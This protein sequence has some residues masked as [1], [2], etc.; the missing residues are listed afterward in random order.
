[1]L[2]LFPVVVMLMV[3][4]MCVVDIVVVVVPIQSKKQKNEPTL[5]TTSCIRLT[6]SCNICEEEEDTKR[7]CC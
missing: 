5:K 7:L 6:D 3:I 2:L 4:P 1:M